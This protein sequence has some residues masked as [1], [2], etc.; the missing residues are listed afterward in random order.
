MD[1]YRVQMTPMSLWC[2]LGDISILMGYTIQW[3]L[4]SDT[5]RVWGIHIPIQGGAKQLLRVSQ[6]SNTRR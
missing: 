1:K 4:G 5:R 3:F 6:P 2:I